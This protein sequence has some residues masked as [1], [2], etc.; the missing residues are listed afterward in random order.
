MGFQKLKTIKVSE[1][2]F[3]LVCEKLDL[4]ATENHVRIYGW[5]ECFFNHREQGYMLHVSSLDNRKDLFVWACEC[6]NSD[7]IMVVHSDDFPN[8]EDNL[9]SEEDY[10][11]RT[12]YFKYHEL[13][14]A[15]DHILD[16][17]KEKFEE[18]FDTDQDR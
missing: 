1:R 10:H 2:V 15:A 12:I 7:E 13:Q 6:R 3:D 8:F 5:L 14:K 11:K 9:F 17:V 4:E 18:E 16:L